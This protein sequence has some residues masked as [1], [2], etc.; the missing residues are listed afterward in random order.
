VCQTLA[1]EC[2]AHD[3]TLGTGRL[4]EN[5]LELALPE[6]GARG[7]APGMLL[8]N[9]PGGVQTVSG[10]NISAIKSRIVLLVSVVY[11]L[12]LL[13]VGLVAAY[14]ISTQNRAT[15]NAL[16][17]SQARANKASNTQTAILTMGKAQAQLVSTSNLEQRRTA[18][19][20][21]IRALSALDEN[22]QQLQKTLPG[23]PKV[24]EL[25]T[26]LALIAPA[27]MEV[28]KAVRAN[29][30]ATA[31]AKVLAMESAME[32][33]EQLSGDAVQE[34]QND[35]TAAV[36][37]QEKRGNATIR[38]LAAAV[39]GGMIV[40]VLAGW[41]AERLLRA[42]EGA[43][44]ANRSKSEF[45]AN[46]SHEIRTPMNGIIGMTDLALDTEL[47]REQRD[48][49][50]MVKSSADSL[51]SLLNDILDFSKIEA[52]KLVVESI[53]FSL[54]GCLGDAMKVLGLRANERG[55]EL[56]CHIL[57]DVPDNLLGD[58]TRLRQI[59]IN[60]AGNA[61]K[62][63]SSGEVVLR[64]ESVEETEHETVL[65]FAVRDTG[66]GIP[67]DKQ[68]AIFEAF[69]QAD[70]S[71]TRRYGG[72][73]LG[74]AISKRI[75]D[76]MGGRLWVESE[77]GKGSTFGFTARFRLPQVLPGKQELGDME[78]VRDLR[79]LVVDD[80]ATSRKILE[81]MLR[82]WRMNPVMAD[83]G[84][85]AL[86]ALE[87]ASAEG[88]VFSLVLLDT[89]MPG[90]EGFAVAERIQKDPRCM[91]P[92]VIM[93]T[94]A[95]LRGDAARCRELGIRAYLPKPVKQ[96]DLLE[97]IKIALAP[98]NQTEGS[99]AL[100][101]VHSIRKPS[102]RLNILLAEDNAINQKLAVRVLEKRG[103][104]VTVAGTGK[105]A[106][107]ILENQPFDLVLMDVQMPEMDG[108]EATAAIRARERTTGKHTP[109][110]AMT[111]NAMVG[112]RERC[113][114]AGMDGYVSKPLQIKELF[115]VIE[116]C[117]RAAVVLAPV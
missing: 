6:S 16:E 68:K 71:T 13:S 36:A 110:V 30:L 48:Y 25:T 88:Q 3:E 108:L 79:V 74:L 107:E 27:K 109:I 9:T 84:Q 42:K 93:L 82:S 116:E 32:R 28:I 62:F 105:S 29:D 4:R 26:L 14:T 115:A 33:V 117:T 87:R 60:L 86:D 56:A 73:G 20:L 41:F 76:V 89:Q 75:V 10:G 72:T 31:R 34:Q 67:L 65:R 63:T 1:Q 18:A 77:P 113:L 83:D 8:S 100:I 94:S 99:P 55:L 23:N 49:L 37:D 17:Q 52:G 58:P 7:I 11:S 69:T 106:L 5:P 96:S 97:A 47:T 40:S 66:I 43:E 81:D 38:V 102:G 85:Q 103:H 19:V 104:A 78:S 64:V 12:C 51:L 21:A 98:Q 90:V 24:L 95:G 2:N 112:D 57:P 44:A 45:L 92:I 53:D 50:T 80:N 39:F 70:S 54:R 22:I 46:M 61:I 35:L 59:A 114:E 91:G 101:T 111:A 15:A